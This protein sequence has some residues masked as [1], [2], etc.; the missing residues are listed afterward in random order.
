MKCVL[1]LPFAGSIAIGPSIT[2]SILGTPFDWRLPRP[3]VAA[4]AGA[5]STGV[6]ALSRSARS[7]GNGAPRIQGC[8]AR[9]RLLRVEASSDADL[10]RS[11]WIGTPATHAMVSP[12]TALSCFEVGGSRH[13]YPVPG[14][15]DTAP[16]FRIADRVCSRGDVAGA[17]LPADAIQFSFPHGATHADPQ[18][19]AFTKPGLLN[20]AEVTH[21]PGPRKHN[22]AGNPAERLVLHLRGRTCCAEGSRAGAKN[23]RPSLS[24]CTSRPVRRSPRGRPHK[25]S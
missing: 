25:N 8:A 9:E 24:P 7:S 12:R 18:G 17:D 11:H 23:A 19:L 21:P 13:G 15:G 20:K 3:V 4:P 6:P 22:S 14:L 1:P 16:Q 10:S 5:L 2:S